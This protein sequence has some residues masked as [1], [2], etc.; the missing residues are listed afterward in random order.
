[1]RLLRQA[2]LTLATATVGV[3]PVRAQATLKN[4]TWTG[5]S[6]SNGGEEVQL[7]FEVKTSAA[8]ISIDVNAPEQGTLPFSNIRLV[9]D[10][11]MFSIQPAAR[12][13]ARRVNDT[14]QVTFEP[15]PQVN[16][17]LHRQPDGSFTGTCIVGDTGESATLRMVPPSP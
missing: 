14:T 16:C 1:M 10:S 11:L 12:E 13:A 4:G 15:S 5:T 9:N 6:V 7:T 3:L 17:V 8:G 2:F